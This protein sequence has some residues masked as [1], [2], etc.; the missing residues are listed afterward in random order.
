MQ[1]IFL[2]KFPK[3]AATI[4]EWQDWDEKM[5][6]EYPIRFKLANAAHWVEMHCWGL[7]K[8]RFRDA[9]WWVLHRIHPKH[10]NHI[11]KIHTLK[12]GYHDARD[13][14]FYGAFDVFEVFMKNI[15]DG[16]SHHLWDYSEEE[17]CDHMTQEYIDTQQARWVEM[18]E[19]YDYWIARKTREDVLPDFPTIPDEW[20]M[21]AVCNSK[22]DDEPLMESW[23]EIADYH[24]Q[25]EAV[26]EEEDQEMFH[27]L[28]DIRECLWD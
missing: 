18:N 5:E 19:I 9:K 20:G 23:R 3:S 14:I 1:S 27:R 24:R 6:R 26:W 8:A 17:V 12:P 11:I 16:N 22:Y 4:E 25:A 28:V 2:P 21:L 10:R 13:R 15:L 7:P